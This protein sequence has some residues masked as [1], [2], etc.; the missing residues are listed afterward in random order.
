[1]LYNITYT[2]TF[3]DGTLEGATYRDSLKGIG[4]KALEGM[5]TRERTGSIVT[6][7]AGGSRYRI[8]DVQ[9]IARIL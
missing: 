3:I 5:R 4:A 8:T 1:M 9:A 2:K 7:V 6:P